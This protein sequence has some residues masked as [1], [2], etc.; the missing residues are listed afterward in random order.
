MGQA[1]LDPEKVLERMRAEHQVLRW[2]PLPPETERWRVEP[3]HETDDNRE[4]L[5]YLHRH[6]ALPEQFEPGDAGFGPKGKV[7]SIVGRLV[8]RVLGR[9]LR[10]ER[11]VLAHLVRVN[12]ALDHRC[13][14]LTLRTQQL[15]KDMIDRQV[16]EA[17]N[18]AE[19]ALWLHLDPP[20]PVAMVSEHEADV[21]RA[22]PSR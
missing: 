20:P 14:E 11:E 2:A 1:P 8:F 4:S 16:A 18:Q 19:L 7:L 22:L 21:R 6:W 15:S 5:E 13:Q 17:R 9:Y 3:G 12:E 10:E